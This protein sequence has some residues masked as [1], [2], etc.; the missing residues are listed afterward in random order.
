M[1]KD[2]KGDVGKNTGAKTRKAISKKTKGGSTDKQ[3]GRKVNR[4][5]STI[6]KIRSGVIKNPP[7][8]LSAQISKSKPAKAKKT[9]K[10]G[11][12]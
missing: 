8:G 5:G 4:S 3:I 11:K 9:A 10:K 1:A 6:A 12:S 2:V 7:S